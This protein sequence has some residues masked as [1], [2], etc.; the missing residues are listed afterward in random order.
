MEHVGRRTLRMGGS[1]HPQIWKESTTPR[2]TGLVRAD[3]MVSRF[4]ESGIK[5]AL[6]SPPLHPLLLEQLSPGQY[7]GHNHSLSVLSQY[8]GVEVM[9]LVWDD[10]WSDDDFY[11]HNHLDRHGRQTFCVNIAPR[12]HE[13]IGEWRWIL[14]LLVTITGFFPLPLLCIS[15]SWRERG[16]SG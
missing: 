5:V 3:Y 8:D 10:Y 9:N 6:I 2:R 14:L 12:I 15:S 13:I 1:H 7:D 16:T 4:S 11:D